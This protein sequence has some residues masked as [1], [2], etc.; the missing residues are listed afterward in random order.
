[1]LQADAPHHPTLHCTDRKHALL[2]SPALFT[3]L[4]DLR[5][6]LLPVKPVPE[7]QSRAR[8]KNSMAGLRMATALTTSS[9]TPGG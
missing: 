8:E 7:V 5:D 4:P 1:M 9:L 6:V 3:A 2:Y